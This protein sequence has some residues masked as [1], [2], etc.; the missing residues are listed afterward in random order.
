MTDA[1]RLAEPNAHALCAGRVWHV[2]TQPFR[3][4]F[5]YAVHML[6]LDLDALASA[7]DGHRFW[8]LDARNLGSFRRTD[9]LGGPR[10]LAGRVRGLVDERLGFRPSGAVKLLAQPRYF[11]FT[12]NP[13]TFHLCFEPGGD[14]LEAILLEVSNTPWNERHVYALDCRGQ[15][16]PWHFDVAKEF[17]VSPFMPM[18]M[19]Y[20]F[21]FR[22]DGNV[23]EVVKQNFS[24]D[25]LAFAA[26][27]ALSAEPLSHA[28]LT[29]ALLGWPM[30]LKVVAAIYW[31]ALRLWLR[32]A[33][34]HTHV[35]APAQ[36]ARESIGKA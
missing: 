5:D 22:L 21:R 1:G 13:V 17:H 7:F 11:G 8:S 12:F 3:H 14:A 30:T 27:M 16:G 4:G 29:R 34:Y 25:E 10:D 28:A 23:M 32:G 15:R 20:R 31:Q 36:G 33:R 9:H 35:P 2:R 26:R 24:G 19:R 6:L 18:D